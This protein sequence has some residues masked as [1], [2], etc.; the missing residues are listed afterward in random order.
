MADEFVQE[1]ARAGR[2]QHGL[3]AAFVAEIPGHGGPAIRAVTGGMVEVDL[4]V[5][6]NSR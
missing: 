2:M 1:L 5:H 6:G 4:R 3:L